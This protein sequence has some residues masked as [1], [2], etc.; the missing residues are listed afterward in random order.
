M[1]KERA[2]AVDDARAVAGEELDREERGAATG[3]ALIL[4]PSAQQ[5]ELLA[6]TELPDGAV[7]DRTLSVVLRAG[8]ALEL[9]G[10]RGPQVGEL[11]LGVPPCRE[12]I[13]GERRLGEGG[14]GR[15]TEASERV[16]GPT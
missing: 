2:S 14:Q 5:L 13:R 3:G 4:E 12:G 11:T 10:P 8:R 15:Q 7:G 1:M 9:V 16:P 6:V